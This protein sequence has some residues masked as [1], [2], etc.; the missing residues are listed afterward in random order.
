MNILN[1]FGAA[2]DDYLSARILILNNLLIQGC[3]L[4]NTA[5]EKYF[6]A[7]LL[8]YEVDAP[9]HHD[10]SAKIFKNTLRNKFPKIFNEINWEFV[11]LLAKSYKLRYLDD[12]EPDFNLVIIRLKLLSELDFIVNLIETTIKIMKNGNN[13]KIIYLRAIEEKH[14]LLMS[15]NYILYNLDKTD[16]LQNQIDLV[17]EFRQ[18][19]KLNSMKVLYFSNDI[20]N[21]NKFI[22]EGL[23]VDNS[24]ENTYK[25]AFKNC[26]TPN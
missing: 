8:I 10:I 26:N 15:Q 22:F 6:K 3:I 7:L 16:F 2:Y 11:S 23:I 21:D 5:I 1:F 14:V 9:R 13:L 12:I 17:L 4:A 25:F 20:K 18:V 19:N 24:K